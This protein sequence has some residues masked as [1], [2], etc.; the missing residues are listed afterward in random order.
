MG[1]YLG[2]LGLSPSSPAEG[3]TDLSERPLN[4][5]PAQPL[6]QVHR[7]QH[8]HRVH[9]AARHRPARRP[10]NWDPTNP[11]G[12]VVNEAWRRF[13]M[14]RSQNSIMGPLASDWWESYFKR[15]I[16]SLRHP[17]A[18]W[19][20][21]T[22]KIGPPEWTGP[23]S[24]SPAEVINSAGFSPSEKPPGPCAKETVLRALRECKKGK[25]RLEE[26]W[27]HESLDSKGRVP[28][29]RPSAFK[30]LRKNGVLI[31][32]ASRPGPLK[33]S[34]HPWGSDH[35]L[36]KQPSC[37]PMDSL[38]SAY[39]GSPLSSK[40][41]A[42]TSSYSSSRDFSEPW[43]R[44][45]PSASFPIPEWPLKRK[46][47]GHQSHSP[48]PL[49]SET[50]GCS[51]QQNQI[52]LLLYSPESPLSLTPSPQLGCTVPE[53][54]ALGKKAGL[55]W[56]NKAREDTTEVTTDSV[57]ETWSAIQPSLSQGT[58]PQLES[59]N[60][61]QT[62]PGLLAFPQ[63]TGEA[64]SVAHSP[65]K[66]ER[67]LAPRACS[68]SGPLS[69]ISSDSKPTGTYIL[70]T[71]VSHTSP[72]TDTTWPPSTSQAAMPQDS[73]ATI[74]E[75]STLQ[76]TL[77]GGMSSPAP[78]L[79]ESAPP[80][81]TSADHMSKPILGFPPNSEI[82]GSLYSRISVAAAAPSTPGIL[83]PTFT[84]IFG[85]IRPLKT[86][87]LI[88]PFSVKQTSPPPT[89]AS[90]HFFHGLVKATSV[91]MST[92]PTSTSKDSFKPPLD[93]SVVNV[94]STM[95]NTY[96][97]PSTSHTFLLGAACAFRAS[98]SPT[99]GF[100][101]PTHQ[102]TTIPTVQ[103]ATIFSQ[104][105]PSA[106]QIS[107]M[108][109]TANFKAM[110]SPLSASALVTTNQ[111]ALS[112]RIS[113]STSAST[114]LLGSSSRP[115]FPLSLGATPQPVLGAA[116]GQKK[117]VPQAGLGPSFSSS[118]TFGNST[119]AS[120]IPAPTPAQPSFSS[121]TQ[122][123]FGGSAP[124]A[125]TFHMPASLRPDFNKTA[126][127]F[128]SG[129]ATTNGFGVIT[130]T[131]RS[132]ACSSA[133]GST[134]PRP[135]DFG[136]L[137]TPM[138]CGETGI[139]VTAPDISSNSGAFS[140]GAVPS[141]TTSTITPLGKDWGPNN[142]GLTSQG[143]HFAFRRARISA[144]KTVFGDPSMAPFAQR[145]PVPGLVK[146]GSSLGFA[147]PSSPPQGSVGRGSF[148]SSAP[149]FSIGAKSKTPKNREQGHSRRHH[150][151]KK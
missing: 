140:T 141:G 65:V 138:E 102:H 95:G 148:R 4:R 81:A 96:S 25:V 28:G 146:A 36:S 94:T 52:P 53:D 47:N 33:R 109:S 131:H 118:F 2:K 100:I 63:P 17:R 12:W 7:V 50:S 133:F 99:T 143:T 37:S 120:S 103:T 116:Y 24:P 150:A 43:K 74:P 126:V 87:P 45:S 44:S 71:P 104:V 82:G 77:L 13:P 38:A 59:L 27:F 32:F 86:M 66:T 85:S 58:D 107:P 46:E 1:S 121:T 76:S 124:S 151:H 115:H 114:I 62:P 142:Q 49:V 54:L 137:V 92:T 60:K 149:S 97:I 19:S 51:G 18:I 147:M 29:A 123:A 35:S 80:V 15:S 6:H 110:G 91:V 127:G 72:V 145:T 134:A 89:P 122:S 57:S 48:V 34:L 3:R 30:P 78:H 42:V 101:F 16:W 144:R 119:V 128:P 117:G 139:S 20:P 68:Q 135:F 93:I 113:S 106:V 88:A 130:S 105:L 22:I 129:Q 5:R 9:P 8:V 75:G 112:S 125:S 83:T 136:G 23:P 73:P 56:R 31:S 11:T 111:P 132:G 61:M 14:K 40:R 39:T 10:L 21:V 108:R 69:D 67:L 26:P 55:Q 84:P 70:L 90:T 64:I 98:F 79:P 41:N